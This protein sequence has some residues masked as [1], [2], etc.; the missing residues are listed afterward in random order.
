MIPRLAAALR[1]QNVIA[2]LRVIRE[3]ETSQ[4][5]SAYRMVYG[6]ELVDSLDAHPRRP[7]TKQLGRQTITSTAAGAYQFLARTWDECAAALG[8][9]DFSP[10]SQDLA[11]VYLA[12]RRRSLDDVIAGRFDDAVKKCAREWAS[13]PGSPYGQPVMTMAKACATYEQWGGRY[14]QATESTTIAREQAQPKETPI[15][16]LPFLAAALP[17]LIEAVPKLA[18]MFGSGSEVSERNIKA[19]ELVVGIAKESIGARNEQELVETMKLDPGA[20]QTVRD[21]IEANWGRIDE[22]GGGI[23]A[24]RQA[25]VA[26]SNISPK[27]NMALWVTVMLLPLVYMTV[28]S[29]IFTSG[30]TSETRAMVVAAVISGVL[31]AITGYWLGTSFSSS[32]K[33]EM[34]A[35]AAQP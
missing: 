8:L 6:G 28:G 27:R 5:G 18:K 22:I 34:R 14:A 16:P 33:D 31:G 20:A 2:F 1:D 17:A 19:A 23:Q 15:M 29:V 3:G 30:W 7:I 24:A 13:L 11:A 4:Q 25:N 21:A 12:D 10:A 32:K 35:G 26:Q 9:T